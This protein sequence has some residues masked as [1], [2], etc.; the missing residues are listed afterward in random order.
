MAPQISSHP[1]KISELLLLRRL[2]GARIWRLTPAA[3]YLDA[4]LYHH[5]WQ[6]DWSTLFPSFFGPAA[7]AAAATATAA[8]RVT[9]LP[10]V[11]FLDHGC[12][13]GG[14]LVELSPMFPNELILGMEIRV[15]VSEYVRDRIVALR[16]WVELRGLVDSVICSH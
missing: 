1:S 16:R 12:G 9:E 2:Y 5:P 7:A 6:A 11:T 10:K 3:P 8:V 14:M 15:K 13:Y 4:T